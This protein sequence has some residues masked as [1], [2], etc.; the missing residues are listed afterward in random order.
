MEKGTFSNS[1]AAH[2]LSEI[3]TPYES[4]IVAPKLTQFIQRLKQCSHIWQ[5]DLTYIEVKNYINNKDIDEKVKSY[6]LNVLKEKYST[7]IKELK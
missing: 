5:V 3:L 4:N 6:T 2:V 1:K 7:R